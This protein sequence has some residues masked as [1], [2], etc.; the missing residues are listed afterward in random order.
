VTYP[1][2]NACPACRGLGE[3]A[4]GRLCRRCQGSGAAR[5]GDPAPKPRKSR[6]KPAPRPGSIRG[7]LAREY[8]ALTEGARNGTH[9]DAYEQHKTAAE[10][11]TAFLRPRLRRTGGRLDAWDASILLGLV[12]LSRMAHGEPVKDHFG[13]AGNYFGGLAWECF[14][15]GLEDHA[16]GPST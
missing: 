10:L 9:G 2:P 12:K 7:D 1:P 8:A 4:A 3:S 16:D 5:K 13:D 11:A 15:R 6:R 14:L